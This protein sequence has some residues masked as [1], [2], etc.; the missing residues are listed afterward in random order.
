MRFDLITSKFG[1]IYL[2]SVELDKKE[3]ETLTQVIK[4]LKAVSFGEL[5]IKKHNSVLDIGITEKSRYDSD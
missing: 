3:T 4:F 2:E 1:N 5:T